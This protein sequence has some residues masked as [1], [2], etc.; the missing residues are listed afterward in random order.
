MGAVKVSRSVSALVFLLCLA[1]GLKGACDP[2]AKA[3][4][5]SAN[6]STNIVG[7]V[8]SRVATWGTTGVQK[9]TVQFHP[10]VGRIVRV[11]SVSGDV[12]AWPS[13]GGVRPALVERGRFAG[14]LMGLQTSGPDGSVFAIPAADNTFLYVQGVVAQGATRVPFNRDVYVDLPAD[15][16]VIVK[17]ASWLNDTGCPIHIEP[18]FTIRYRFVRPHS[19]TSRLQ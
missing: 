8:D 19:R 1:V 9:W 18:T 6:F 2:T 15:S 7:K 12:V 14:L 3:C 17:V 16:K 13:F 5:L 10:P 11:L 4:V